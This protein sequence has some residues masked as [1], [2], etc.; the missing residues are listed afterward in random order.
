MEYAAIHIPEFPV[1]AWL[2]SDAA[3]RS[4]ALAV[5]EG[6]APLQVVVSINRA[7]RNQGVSRGMSKVQAEATGSLIFRNRSIAEETASFE[8]VLEIAERFS[9]RI[10]A[11]SG[12][13]NSYAQ[14]NTLSVSLL[15]DRTGTET[16]FGPQNSTPES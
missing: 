6:I 4:H 2:R 5:T 7:A 1:V 9:P 13:L 16:L 14:A 10:E 3:A 11:L 8:D 15:I 12:P